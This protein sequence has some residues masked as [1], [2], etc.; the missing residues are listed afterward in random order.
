MSK[1][2][3]SFLFALLV[4]ISWIGSFVIAYKYYRKHD[5]SN[6]DSFV[7]GFMWMLS[8]FMGEVFFVMLWGLFYSAM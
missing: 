6:D 3:T 2:M 7:F 4:I 1:L 8:T 5:Y